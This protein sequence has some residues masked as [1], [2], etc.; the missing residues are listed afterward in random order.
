MALRKWTPEQKAQ[1]VLE[2]LRGRSV[3]EICT[4]HAI[5][6]NMY[7]R[8]RDQLLEKA[9]EVFI[10]DKNTRRTA[11]LERENTRLKGLVG[12]LTLELKK[13]DLFE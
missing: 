2:G 5:T 9:H 4:E 8:W 13:S 10:S 12:E 3:T 1:I 6:Q 7:Y 11:K